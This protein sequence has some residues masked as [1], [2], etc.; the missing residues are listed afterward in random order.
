MHRPRTLRVAV[1]SGAT[2]LALVLSACGDGPGGTSSGGGESLSMEEGVEVIDGIVERMEAGELEYDS[3]ASTD[4]VIEAIQEA[5]PDPPN[6]YPSRDVEVLIGFGEGGGSD[7]YARNIALDAQRIMGQ[8]L[9]MNNIPGAGGELALGQMFSGPQDG[10]RIATVITN[11][12]INDAL[13]TMPYNFVDDVTFVIRQQG[14]TETYWVREDNEWETF[15]D[16]LDYAQENPGEVTVSGS[17]LGGDDEFRLYALGQELDTSFNFVP[18]DGAGGRTTALLS[19][20]ID[21][22]HETA[23]AMMDLYEDGQIRPLAYGGDIV[24]EGIDPDIPSVADLGYPVPVGRWRGIVVPKDLD[25][26][27]VNYL[28]HVFYAASQLPRYKEYEKEFFQ[29]IAGGYLN[30]HDF[31][32]AARA[33][34]DELIRLIEDLG[35]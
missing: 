16:M 24:F 35:L 12:V 30:G 6:D 25:E 21:M 10:H 14:P 2:A 20:D 27:T 28:H 11:Q 3:S 29:D 34:R 32:E 15:E 5:I 7:Q 31:E 33:E 8:R 26:D 13:D 17:G 18:Y 23:G 22:L 4:E 19:G 1:T 9:I